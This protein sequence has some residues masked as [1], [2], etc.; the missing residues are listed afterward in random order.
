[1][2]ST[3][4]NTVVSGISIRR[5]TLIQVYWGKHWDTAFIVWLYLSSYPGRRRRGKSGLVP[6]AHTCVNISRIFTVNLSLYRSWTMWSCHRKRIR[7]KYTVDGSFKLK[8]TLLPIVTIVAT[9][10]I[11]LTHPFG[12]KAVVFVFKKAMN[13]HSVTK[14]FGVDKRGQMSIQPRTC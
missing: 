1:M 4:I 7:M 9:S 5:G 10:K 8:G 12:N 2:G 14:L 3:Y 11:A 6:I 13:S